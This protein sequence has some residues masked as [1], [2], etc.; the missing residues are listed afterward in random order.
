MIQLI[1]ANWQVPPSVY[2]FS[3]TRLGGFSASPF[4]SLNLGLHVGDNLMHVQKNRA[5]LR[6]YLQLPQEPD[7]LEQTHSNH[8]VVVEQ[9]DQRQADAAITRSSQHV[10]AIMT[11]DCLPI[12]LCDN[13]GTEIAAIHAGWRGLAQG[14]VEN[15]INTMRTPPQNLT[16]WI[17]PA[18]CGDCYVVN[19]EFMHAFQE[20]YPF[21]NDYFKN[22]HTKFLA[23]LPA[24]A[25]KILF[26]LQITA[27]F[28]TTICTFEQKKDFF[29]YR[30]D[31]QTGR[32]A[33][34]IWFN[35]STKD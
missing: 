10:L 26:N 21:A 6:D 30:R 27:V 16:A 8:C 17:G 2:A 18:I 22:H 31:L 5:T 29:S 24:L 11:A 28:K 13:Q 3:T 1:K 19:E 33:T 12:L 15:T 20:K 4:D 35:N 32:I 7:W 25:E 14:I 23:D 34:L 9:S